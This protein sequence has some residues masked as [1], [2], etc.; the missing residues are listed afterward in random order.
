MRKLI[1]ACLILLA[2]SSIAISDPAIDAGP[3][4]DGGSDATITDASVDV[5]SQSDDGDGLYTYCVYTIARP[6]NYHRLVEIDC[7]DSNNEIAFDHYFDDLLQITCS[8]GL[9]ADEVER[10]LPQNEETSFFYADPSCSQPIA[11]VRLAGNNPMMPYVGLD[12][13]KQDAA[14]TDSVFSI[15]DRWTGVQTNGQFFFLITDPND[16]QCFGTYHTFYG[17]ALYYVGAPV[18]PA[19]FMER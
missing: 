16:T 1:I 3:E 15:G 9:A 17:F 4:I 19:T 18:A 7:V 6:T 11:L 13:Y 8:W 10:C 12:A 14:I 2:C 5:P